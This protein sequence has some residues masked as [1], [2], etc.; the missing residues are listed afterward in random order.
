MGE[1]WIDIMTSKQVW[2]LGTFAQYLKD[3]GIDT[4]VTVRKYQENTEVLERCMES[5]IFDFEYEITG[6]HGGQSK[7]GKLKA[8]FDR[9]QV[10]MEGAKKRDVACTFTLS[11]PEAIR[12]AYGLGIP[13]VCTSDT[14]FAVAVSKLTFP[15]SEKL[16]ISWLF[17]EWEFIRAGA[18]PNSII[19]FEGIDEIAWTRGF[20]PNP[21]IL[22][23]IGLDKKRPIVIVRALSPHF[24]V[25][26]HLFKDT[27]TGVEGIISELL[28]KCGKEIQI[29]AIPRYGE[30]GPILRKK[31]GGRISVIDHTDGPSLSSYAS[32]LIAAGGTMNRE[33]ALLGTYAISMDPMCKE[34]VGERYLSEHGLMSTTLDPKEAVRRVLELTGDPEKRKEVRAKAK[35][36]RE[37]LE[38]PIPVFYKAVESYL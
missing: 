24:T 13:N 8:Y 11:S 30:Q 7:E 34:L 37:S 17:D 27:E 10:L 14:P 35:K 3:K 9:C 22:D 23:E 4:W 2:F 36:V 18:D 33:A 31:F 25:F 32:V 19:K 16:I 1:V 6:V 15:F 28:R 20:K 21:K 38:D 12:V 26:A 29:V 5:G